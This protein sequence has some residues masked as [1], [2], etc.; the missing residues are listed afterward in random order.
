MTIRKEITK[1][2]R[3]RIVYCSDEATTHL[4]KLLK[5]RK[6]DLQPDTLIFSVKMDAKAPETIYYKMLL[7]FEKLQ[8]IADKD[9]RNKFKIRDPEFVLK[10]RVIS[11]LLNTTM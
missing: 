11:R 8:A 9:Q 2:K 6:N 1:T 7:Q 5:F 4:Q 10:M 3:S